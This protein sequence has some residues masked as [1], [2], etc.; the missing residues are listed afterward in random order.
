MHNEEELAVVRQHNRA[1]RTV[2]RQLRRALKYFTE[3]NDEL[4]LELCNSNKEAELAFEKLWTLG[5]ITECGPQDYNKIVEICL[6][7]MNVIIPIDES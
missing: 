5:G 7:K 4:F 1:L 3:Y 2:H 6:S